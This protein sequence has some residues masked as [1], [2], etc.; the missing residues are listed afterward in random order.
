MS[1]KKA[2]ASALRS[3]G[4]DIAHAAC[5]SRSAAAYASRSSTCDR[6]SWSAPSWRWTAAL[7]GV[8]GDDLPA[9]LGAEGAG[10]A[11]LGVEA[12]AL[13]LLLG[14]AP[15]VQGD[16]LPAMVATA[17]HWARDRRPS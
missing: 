16:P 4:S 3:S 7:V 13:E 1:S 5:T 15:D 12:V 2:R 8:L 11:A 10:R 6:A 9:P 17:A 14:G